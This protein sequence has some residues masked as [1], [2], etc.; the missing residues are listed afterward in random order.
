MYKQWP[1]FNVLLAN[2][3][4][5]L[6]KAEMT[7]AKEYSTLCEDPALG[8]TIYN[9]VREEFEKTAKHVLQVVDCSELLEENPT[10]LLSLKRRNPY[11]DPLSHIQVKLLRRY[12]RLS[13]ESPDREEL[14]KP[15][16][17]SISAIATG[18]RNT[19]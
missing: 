11:L 18:M 1:F 7:I 19:G 14:L 4:M 12:R 10:L 13:V 16:L 17:R 5:S 9:I 3:Q 15:L 6:Y 2:L 8:E